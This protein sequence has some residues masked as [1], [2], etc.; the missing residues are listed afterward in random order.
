MSLLLVPTL[1]TLAVT[2]ARLVGEREGCGPPWFSNAPGGGYAIVGI[3]WLVPV[4]GAWFGLRL[5]RAGVRPARPGRSAL[6]HLVAVAIYVGGFAA[7]G[8]ID[9]HTARGLVQQL[10]AMG[11]VAVLAALAALLAWPRLFVV[12]LLYAMLARVP[13]AAITVLAVAR[14]WDVHLVKFGKDD[15]GLPPLQAAC[16][17]AFT[18][19]VFWTAV[20]TAVG[21]LFGV[22]AAACVRPTAP[23]PVAGTGPASGAS[24][25]RNPAK[26]K[27]GAKGTGAKGN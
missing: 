17:L 11:G 8:R 9:T 3:V 18:Q 15:F 7:A 26:G 27:A 6:L 19:L 16:W 14:G 10:L 20:T 21:G 13:V 5:A 23:V 1:V 4:F 24:K 22:L 25:G 12:D 2:I